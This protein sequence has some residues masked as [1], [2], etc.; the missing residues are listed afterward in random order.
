MNNPAPQMAVPAPVYVV[1]RPATSGKAT[2]S[3]VLSLCALLLFGI[4]I[5]GA[6]LSPLLI[7][8]AILGIILGHIALSDIKKHNVGGH[9][10]AVWGL[11]LGY[12]CLG[13]QLWWIIALAGAASSIAGA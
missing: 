9:S 10:L 5:L 2:A 6:I 8:T 7:V 12:V 11:V 4:P 1:A 13:L 3:L